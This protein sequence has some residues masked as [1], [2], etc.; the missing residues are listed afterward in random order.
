MEE[1]ACRKVLG[2]RRVWLLKTVWVQ[3]VTISE[4]GDEEGLRETIEEHQIEEEA[5]ERDLNDAPGQ[6]DEPE[7]LELVNRSP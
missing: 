7:V 3:T 1:S 5:L 6:Q 4:P 2:R